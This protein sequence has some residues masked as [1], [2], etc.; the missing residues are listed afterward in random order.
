MNRILVTAARRAAVAAMVALALGSCGNANG[1]RLADAEQQ[2]RDL[3]VQL[4]ALAQNAFSGGGVNVK[5]MPDPLTGKP[6]VPMDEVFSFNRSYAM[7]EVATNPRAF[8]M[9]TYAMGDVTIQ[10]NQFYMEMDAASID[11]IVIT[12]L[13]NG[14]RKLKMTGGLNCSTEVGQA[15]VRIGSRTAPEHARYEITAI[16]AGV[17]GGQ[18]G[19]SFSFTAFFTKEEAPVNYGIFGPQATFT[20]QMVA[21]EIIIVDPAAVQ[22]ASLK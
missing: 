15:K 20:G 22:K 6:T 10:P 12:T 4:S 8:R 16:D 3:R 7:C 1:A 19:D 17:G 9:T 13:N 14:D 5:M 11:E 2:V 21:G 18:A